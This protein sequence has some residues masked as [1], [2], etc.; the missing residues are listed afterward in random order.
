MNILLVDGIK[1]AEI[2]ELSKL[3]RFLFSAKTVNYLQQKRVNL[4]LLERR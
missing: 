1:N 3:Q 2:I 4:K